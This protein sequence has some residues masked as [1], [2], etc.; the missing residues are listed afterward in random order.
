MRA[1][2]RI[3]ECCRRC[4]GLALAVGAGLLAGTVWAAG[5]VVTQKDKAFSVAR[6]R[7]HVGEALVIRNDD[8]RA[9]NIQVNHPAL[10]YNS[11]LQEPGEDVRLT[12][13]A[14]GEYLVFCGIHPKM[15]LRAR[16]E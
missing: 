3:D 6:V 1:G 10:V 5:T 15:K 2:R 9:H 7:L 14:A 12:F 16:V 4:G 13:P 11:G 8:T